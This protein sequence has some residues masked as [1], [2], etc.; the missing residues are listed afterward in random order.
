MRGS[1]K[2]VAVVVLM[3]AARY[4]PLGSFAGQPASPAQVPAIVTG[5]V[6][7]EGRPAGTLTTPSLLKRDSAAQVRTILAQ[8]TA[9]RSA[10]PQQWRAAGKPGRE[11]EGDDDGEIYMG[12]TGLL[13]DVLEADGDHPLAAKN[14]NDFLVICEA[15]CRPA[16]DRIVYRVSKIAAVAAAKAERKMEVTSADASAE[17]NEIVCVAGCYDEPVKRR[18]ASDERTPAAVQL[19][20]NDEARSALDKQPSL[21]PVKHTQPH[22]AAAVVAIQSDSDSQAIRAKKSE[23]S[24]ATTPASITP[25]F[26]PATAQTLASAM[27]AAVAVPAALSPAKP[28]ALAH[29]E[30]PGSRPLQ[31]LAAIHAISAEAAARLQDKHATQAAAVRALQATASA[32]DTNVLPVV[33]LTKPARVR[34]SVVALGTVKPFQ[35]SIS[36]ENGWDFTLVHTP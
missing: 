25:P 10:N 24:D 26:V 11:D 28:E 22:A 34:K 27:P 5:S 14:P 29:A 9:E 4:A 6:Q 31:E 35:T 33:A 15:G 17:N 16:S 2:F 36:I 30:A 19:A 12:G 23:Q 18:Q 8:A 1:L 13:Q 32:W 20:Q 21:E 7:D 3:A